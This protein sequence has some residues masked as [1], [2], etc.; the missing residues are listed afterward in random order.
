[1]KKVLSVFLAVL[2]LF[3]C[4]AISASAVDGAYSDYFGDGTGNQPAT[5][6]QAIFVFRLGGGGKCK[7]GYFVYIDGER[8]YKDAEDIPDTFMVVPEN[9]DAFKEGNV[10]SLP[11]VKA[12]NGADFIGWQRKPTTKDGDKDNHVYSPMA[13]QYTVSS[14]DVGSIV[15]FTA[16]YEQGEFE[17][18]T[19]AKVFEILTKV[20][21]AII[22]L[23]A[24]QGNI[25]KGQ[26]FMKQIFASL[27]D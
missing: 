15:E 10:F 21:G 1:M 2:M 7:K 22:G 24:Y 5:T 20:F 18:D 6:D 25:E 27:S 19:F 16:V 11:S 13:G 4:M 14:Y 23:V 26:N 8:V 3:S 9:A 17:Q 12:N